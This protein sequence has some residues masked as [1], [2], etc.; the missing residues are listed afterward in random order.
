MI[1]PLSM[2]L[3]VRNTGKFLSHSFLNFLICSR[4]RLVN[5]SCQTALTVSIDGHIFTVIE[6]DGVEHQ[7][8]AV[9][10]LTIFAGQ[11][12][13]VIVEANQTVDN[14]CTASIS[15]AVSLIVTVFTPGFRTV[16][17]PAIV[18]YTSSG[19]TVRFP[20]TGHSFLHR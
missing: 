6:A 1:W 9:D 12:Y 7:P 3:R 15:F 18:N 10:S 19:M 16:P 11:R 14:Y 5:L 2:S 4:F 13:S 17:S 20:S 8:L